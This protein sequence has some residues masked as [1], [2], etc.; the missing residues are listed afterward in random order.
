MIDIIPVVNT[1]PEFI[2]IKTLSILESLDVYINKTKKI[3]LPVI[4]DA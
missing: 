1:A 2:H 4:Q 3:Y